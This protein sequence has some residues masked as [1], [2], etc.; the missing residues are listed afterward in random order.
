[1]GA[2]PET[3]EKEVP[4][5]EVCGIEV[6]DYKPQICCNAFDCGCQG[7]PLFP[8]LCSEECYNKFMIGSEFE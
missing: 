3:I 8:P 4:K 1:M 7:K 2:K 6:P 5:C